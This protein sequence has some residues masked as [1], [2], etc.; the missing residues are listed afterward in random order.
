MAIGVWDHFRI[1]SGL[2]L[3]RLPPRS[4]GVSL[5]KIQCQMLK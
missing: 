2:G 3:A 1:A 4:A 5:G